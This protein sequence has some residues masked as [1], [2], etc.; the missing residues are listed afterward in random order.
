M[1][2]GRKYALITSST[3]G[4]GK[5]IGKILL[6]C[7]YYV[8][9]N[10]SKNEKN[11][12]QLENE[13]KDYDGQYSIIKSD[14]STYE[15]IDKLLTEVIK[16]SGQLDYIVLNTGIT[17][18]KDF[19]HI[20]INEWNAVMD[21]NLNIP[22][23]IV[24]AFS[25]MIRDNGR[26]V[27]I[28]ALMG[29]IPHAISI[30]YSVSKAGLHMLAKSLVKVFKDRSITINVIAPGFIDTDWQSDKDNSH[31]KRIED[32][33]ALNRFG[34]A[35]EVANV[36]VSIIA[37]PYINGAIINVDGGYSME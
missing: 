2:I 13:I 29:I 20:K 4:I 21:T 36:C 34:T 1:E 32:K 6:E 27:F 9:F 3:S 24:Q 35:E 23:F 18:R 19:N 7:G 22:F 5:G 14:L 25:E 8:F 17:N 16:V 37:N 30:P 11:K 12:R 28:G 15:G 31:R 33:I 10:Y 26:I